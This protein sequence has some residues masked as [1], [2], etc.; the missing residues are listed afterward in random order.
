MQ[1]TSRK[2]VI[3]ILVFAFFLLIHPSLAPAIELTRN[4]AVGS[5]G[6]DVVLLQ[7]R[8]AELG[9]LSIKPTGYFGWLT[10]QAVVRFEKAWGLY[11]DGVVTQKE[12]RLLF[13]QTA[14]RQLPVRSG[15]KVI[16]GYYP[17]DYPGDKAAYRSLASF[18]QYLSA[19]GI[20]CL[21]LG[22]QGDLRGTLP[23]E[24]VALANRY[25][26]KSLLVV[27][28]Y[29]NGSFDRQLVHNLLNSEWVQNRFVGNVL[30]LLKTNGLSGLNIDLEN[31]PPGD[32]NQLNLFLARLA[33]ALKPAGYSFIVT[34]PAKTGDDPQNS[35][36]GAFDY[37][38]ISQVCDYIVL[39]TYDEHWLGSS[40]GPVASLPWVTKVLDFA[41]RY[42]P[43]EK[44]L[45]G[46]P[47]YGYD[48]SAR[49]T[50]VVRWNQVNQLINQYGWDKVYWDDVACVP[51]LRYW[52]AA[53]VQH[54][55]W[56][57]NQYSLKIKLALVKNYGLAGISIWRLGFEDAVFWETV[58]SRL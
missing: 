50:K 15:K 51:S 11:P 36:N 49:G 57:E 46:I 24:G 6:S 17:V 3:S 2:V 1:V 42:V 58:Q 38:F 34:V 44:I 56:F 14:S 8:L 21:S 9:Y 30:Q 54:E 35:W 10:Y 28:N 33:A 53:G 5:R 37:Q 18:G 55:V 32:R 31:V 40:P 27:H 23:S 47:T 22:D 16:F 43:K 7:S 48:W 4:L 29:R 20:F 45:L 12:W 26:V 19:I 39:M 25:G 41:I 13:P 52:D